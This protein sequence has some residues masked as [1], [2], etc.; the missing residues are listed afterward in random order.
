MV[1]APAHLLTSLTREER[2]RGYRK[3]EMPIVAVKS[4][5][6]DGAKGHRFEITSKGNMTRHRADSDHDNTNYSFHTVGAG[7]SAAKV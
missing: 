5:N 1:G 3:S 6:A 4:G 7:K 2:G